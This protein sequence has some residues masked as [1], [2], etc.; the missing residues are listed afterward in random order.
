M[1]MAASKIAVAIACIKGNSMLPRCCPQN[2]SSGA[3]G[4]PTLLEM[5]AQ[6]NHPAMCVC[7]LGGLRDRRLASG[8]FEL[9]AAESA[10]Q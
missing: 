7:S 9:L 5:P 4:I 10:N 6:F 2:L 3:S 8:T 1:E